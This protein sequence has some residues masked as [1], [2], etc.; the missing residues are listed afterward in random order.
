[1]FSKKKKIFFAISFYIDAKGMKNFNK[2]N[3]LSLNESKKQTL[4]KKYVKK[5]I[6]KYG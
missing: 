3:F 4:R 2:T 6:K 1:L 5:T